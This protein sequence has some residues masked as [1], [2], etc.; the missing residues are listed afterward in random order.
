VD[1]RGGDERRG[2]PERLRPGVE[3]MRARGRRHE[4]DDLDDLDVH[5]VDE[6]DGGADDRRPDDDDADDL[7]DEHDVRE[8][9]CR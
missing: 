5:D 1:P 4:L 7:D 6:L 8:G 3:R 9:L 2:A